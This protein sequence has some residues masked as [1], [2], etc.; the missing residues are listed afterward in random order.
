MSYLRL[1]FNDRCD[2][3]SSSNA[4]F[5]DSQTAPFNAE[6]R[7]WLNGFFA[8]LLGIESSEGNDPGERSGDVS[9]TIA[10]LMP[11][12]HAAGQGPDESEDDDFPWHDPTLAIEERAQ[13]AQ[14]K[15]FER[16]LMA[17]MAQLDCGTCSYLCKRTQM[18]L[19]MVKKPG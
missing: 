2:A 8:G 4:Y 15:P 7:A 11:N 9:S 10:A 6:Q 5:I 1:Q 16:Q 17:A 3:E 19:P 13:L 18:P 14:D 12:A